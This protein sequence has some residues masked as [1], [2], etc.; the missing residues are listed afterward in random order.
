[1]TEQKARNDGAG[2]ICPNPNPFLSCATVAIA[3]ATPWKRLRLAGPA[4]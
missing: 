1:M 3:V 4:L 2:A